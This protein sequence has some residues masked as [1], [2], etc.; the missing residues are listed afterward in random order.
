MNRFLAYKPKSLAMRVPQWAA[1]PM[2]STWLILVLSVVATL[3]STL[4]TYRSTEILREERFQRATARITT[5]LDEL[6]LP[7]LRLLTA[8]SSLYNVH[9]ELSDDDWGIF[10]NSVDMTVQYPGLQGL[11]YVKAFTAEQLPEH[12]KFMRAKRPDY[13]VRPAE[14]RAFYTAVISLW[15]TNWRNERPIGFDMFTEQ[16][17]RNAM[18]AA[19]DSGVAMLSEPVKLMQEVDAD[20]QAGVLL[21]QPI[22][23]SRDVPADLEARRRMLSGYIFAAFRMQDLFDSAFGRNLSEQLDD[24]GMK[25]FDR[26]PAS[27]GKLLFQGGSLAPATTRAIVTPTVEI[28]LEVRGQHWLLQLFEAQSFKAVNERVLP[29][30]VLFT[31]L[32]FAAFVTGIA[33]ILAMSRQKA[34]ADAAALAVEVETRKQVQEALERANVEIRISNQELVHRVKNMMAVVSSIATQTARFSPDPKE[35]NDAFR[36]RLAALG[37]VHDYL[38]PQSQFRPD[39]RDLIPTILEPYIN[40]N[41]RLSEII[42]ESQDVSQTA[43]VMLSIAINELAANAMRHGAWSVKEGRVKLAWV[44]TPASEGAGSTLSFEWSETGGPIVTSPQHTGFGSYVLRFSIEQGLKGTYAHEYTQEGLVCR[45][46][47]PMERLQSQGAPT[48]VY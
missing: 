24:I 47:L 15:P 17:R 12:L 40:Q 48:R 32:V 28:P 23:S 42:G 19:R 6:M 33:S 14:P 46:A 3:V 25:V 7:Y 35:F 29:W 44:L 39:V 10:A 38:K 2:A 8:A 27:G 30:L 37:R 26:P 4:V 9:G 21:Y 5:E 13:Q 22:Y 16:N 31:G 34:L 43:A 18:S 20:Q 36:D 11:G 1:H 45:W 41:H